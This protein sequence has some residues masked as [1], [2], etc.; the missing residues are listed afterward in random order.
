MRSFLDRLY[1]ACLL[2]AALCLIGIALLVGLQLL[3]RI[4]DGALRL[5]GAAP[6]GF[7]IPS[8]AEFAA[9]L[10]AA[11]SFFALAGTFKSG[12]HIRVTM[13]LGAVG[14]A[15]RRPLEI[16]ALGATTVLCAFMTFSIGRFAFYSYV[17]HEISP[18]VIPVPLVIPQTAMTVGLLVLT[19]ALVDEFVL[20]LRG[21]PP[22]F[23]AAE[24]AATL[25]REG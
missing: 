15:R 16:W 12:G 19:V 24:E 1:R 25:S 5:V 9:N 4:A 10:L 14:E 7:V 17:F 22:S 8:A 6:V 3:G 23:R 21:L 2:L 18:G 11:A 20:V 13:L